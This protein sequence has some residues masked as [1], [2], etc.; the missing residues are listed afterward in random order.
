[1]EEKRHPLS[2]PQLSFV[3]SS[4]VE[5][6]TI[7]TRHQSKDK[8]APALQSSPLGRVLPL[9]FPWLHLK[10]TFHA[11][12]PADPHGHE[13]G[14]EDQDYTAGGSDYDRQRADL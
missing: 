11:P 1:M 14:E 3:P 5:P 4:R 10:L 9:T 13:D 2:H 8:R 12:S 7:Q 6:S